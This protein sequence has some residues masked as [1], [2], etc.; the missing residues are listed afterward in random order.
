MLKK[1]YIFLS[2][3]IFI[4]SLF[5][6]FNSTDLDDSFSYPSKTRY[7]TSNYGYRQLFGKSDFH[8]GT[9]FGA[10]EGSYIYA[11]SSGVVKQT[12]FLIGYGNSV[13]IL[14]QNGY[15]SLYAHLSSDF[16]VNCG[17]YIKKGEIIGKVGPKY[18]EDGR[19]NGYT[20][21]PHL[22]LTIF[23]E[24]GK[25]INPINLLKSN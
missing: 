23:D 1:Y 19:L 11:I 16:L 12:G 15:K 7:I 18:L 25:T 20:T 17:D 21:G 22:H 14:H 3:F 24:N 13:T 10:N 6:S 9:D 2:I 8:N 5:S 4:L